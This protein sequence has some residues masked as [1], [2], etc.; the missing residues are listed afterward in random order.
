MR[1]FA[2][3]FPAFLHPDFAHFAKLTNSRQAY[4]SY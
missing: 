3:L 2:T 4:L 1:F